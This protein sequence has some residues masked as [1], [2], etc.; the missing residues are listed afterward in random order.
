MECIDRVNAG[1][2]PV[3]ALQKAPIKI[4]DYLGDYPLS[5]LFNTSSGKRSIINWS[6]LLK[7]RGE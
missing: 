6:I 5:I 7:S 3:V 2:N 1:N 4:G